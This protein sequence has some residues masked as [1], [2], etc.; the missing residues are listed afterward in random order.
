MQ[1][2]SKAKDNSK[3]DFGDTLPAE[4]PGKTGRKRKATHPALKTGMALLM[5]LVLGGG[6][7]GWSSYSALHPSTN[8]AYLS[9]F[10]VRVAPEVSGT[11]KA[12]GAQSFQRVAKGDML[13]R[14]DPRPFQVAVD[15]AEA[16]LALARQQVTTLQRAVG[17]AEAELSGRKAALADTRAEWNRISALVEKGTLP[18]SQGDAQKAALHEAEAAMQAATSTVDS[19]RAKLGVPGDNNPLILSAKAKLEQ[20]RLDLEKTSI[21]APA[22]GYVGEVNL[23]PGSLATAGVEL[24]QLVETGAWW[25]DA[26]FKESDLTRIKPGQK[27]SVSVDMLPGL[28]LT[29]KVAALSPAS[30]ASFALLPPENATGNWVKVTRR[31]PVR[32]DLDPLTGNQTLRL[33]ASSSVTVDTG[34]R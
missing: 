14:I 29:G 4:N 18:K 15:A 24:M 28:N 20:A 31:F 26:N 9:A 22:D 3:G 2:D 34:D 33:G 12:V 7:Y 8:D 13:V 32:I 6:Y 16:E 25:V 23:R 11:I 21:L 1:I 5:L 30:G 10:V 27:A 19:A 17:V